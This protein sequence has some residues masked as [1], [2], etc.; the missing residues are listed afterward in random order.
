MNPL[1]ISDASVIIDIECAKLSKLMFCLPMIFQVPDILFVEEL[2]EHHKHLTQLGLQIKSMD[3]NLVSNAYQLKQ[4]YKKA[5]VNDL[6]ALTL[7]IDQ[8]CQLLT[9]DKELNKIA[10][11]FSI[12]VHGT[13]W[14]VEQLI[15]HNIITV[16]KARLS[17]LRMRNSGSRLPWKEI[18]LR[19][20]KY[21][22]ETLIV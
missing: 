8:N 14:L 10:K 18:E 3:G 7:A 4:K 15:H 9:G 22:E 21:V 20:N 2:E 5:S 19:L 1:I 6:L 13:I 12:E 17:F 16:E 11:C